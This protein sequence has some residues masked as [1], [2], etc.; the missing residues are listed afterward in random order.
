ML[1]PTSERWKTGA[2]TCLVPLTK[3]QLSP[4]SLSS[5]QGSPGAS[6]APPQP[7]FRGWCCSQPSQSPWE[8]SALA[9]PAYQANGNTQFLTPGTKV[10]SPELWTPP[11]T[12]F[13]P[14]SPPTLLGAQDAGG[15]SNQ[16][17]SAAGRAEPPLMRSP[18][19][20]GRFT[21]PHSYMGDSLRQERQV[22]ELF[23]RKVCG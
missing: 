13:S 5:A 10:N 14:Q 17:D 1:S 15:G 12:S 2:L 16:S 18:P 21:T 20:R 11:N 6:R 3:W 4:C 7:W 19:G 8:A 22:W 23:S 9:P